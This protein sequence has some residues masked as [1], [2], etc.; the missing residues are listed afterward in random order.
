MDAYKCQS[1]G[2]VVT[3]QKSH[4]CP[5]QEYQKVSLAPAEYCAKFGHSYKETEVPNT[6]R[7][8]RRN[9][10]VWEDEGRYVLWESWQV[11]K[12]CTVCGDGFIFT[13]E[14]QLE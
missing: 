6:L 10:Q 3:D 5:K 2:S 12:K 11:L 4:I 13:Q 7:K 1:C 8:F 9:T 14:H